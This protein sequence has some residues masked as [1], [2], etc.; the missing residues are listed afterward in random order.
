[1]KMPF[2]LPLGLYCITDRIHSRGRSSIEVVR[3]MLA[4]GAKIVQYREKEG[5]SVREMLAECR[6]IRRLTRDAGAV[7]L[8]ND[9]V[10][11]ALL[12]DA[13][14]VHIGQDD[15][16]LSEV[17]KLVGERVI[18]LSTH[19]IAQAREA[20][21]LGADYIGVGPIFRTFTKKN[22]VDPV[23]CRYLE[24]VAREIPL[25]FVPIG[26]IKEYNIG[27]VLSRGARTVCVV[28]GVTEAEDIEA[29][30]RKLDKIIRNGKGE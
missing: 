5:L 10:D 14:G 8:V 9:H 1:M 7:F 26:G 23:G 16:P 11:L 17:R 29:T 24:E 6:E 3:S 22:V 28:T 2:E 12:C 15:L 30:V 27:E 20:V 21:A 19:S 13:D 4:G 25:P 18:G